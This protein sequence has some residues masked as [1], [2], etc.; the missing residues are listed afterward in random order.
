MK[1]KKKRKIRLKRVAL[2]IL[3]LL[4][5][6]LVI[7]AISFLKVRTYYVYNNKYL[8]DEQVLDILK[9]NKKSSFLFVNTLT[10][11]AIINKNKRIKDVKIKRT[12]ALEAKVYVTEYK[13]LFFDEKNNY[14]V[15]ENGDTISYKYDN[16]PVLVNEIEDK[17]IYKKFLKKMNKVNLD[18]LDVI[19]EIK[20]VPNGIDK[21]RFLFSMNDGN[22]VYVTISKLTKINEYRSV[23]D[24]VE[25]KKGILYLDYGNY[26]VPKEN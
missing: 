23:I 4:I 25:N 17:E 3:L 18:I 6:S 19:S 7:Y 13:I 11:K 12:L 15:I 5:L 1:K 26:F 20:Y 9:L 14:S 10:E 24:S 16:A 22:Y 8:S 21:E 2:A